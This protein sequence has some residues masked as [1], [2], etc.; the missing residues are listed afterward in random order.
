MW[1]YIKLDRE[2]WI[3]IEPAFL[4]AWTGYLMCGYLNMWVFHENGQLVHHPTQYSTERHQRGKNL[5]NG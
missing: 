3:A 4:S 1:M 5:S 2:D